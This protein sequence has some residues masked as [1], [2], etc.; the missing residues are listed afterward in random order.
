MEVPLRRPR[1]GY[2]A[3]IVNYRSYGDLARCLA[4]VKSQS[5]PPARIV[6]VD[7]DSC[8]EEL[9]PLRAAH[10]EV[11]W[12]PLPNRGYSAG[13]NRAIVSCSWR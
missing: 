6:V 2:V 11:R 7:A 12:L 5:L 3:A 13:A 9:R 8:A 4:A 10:A 1:R